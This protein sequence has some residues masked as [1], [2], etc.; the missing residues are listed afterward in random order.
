MSA[1]AKLPPCPVCGAEPNESVL[2]SP[3]YATN[4]AIQC[5]RYQDHL[6]QVAARTIREARAKWRRLAGGRK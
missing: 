3:G 1:P 5:R 2:G 4:C 6:L